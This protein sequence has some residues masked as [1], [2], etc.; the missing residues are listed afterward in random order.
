MAHE[1]YRNV[2]LTLAT[3]LLL[4]AVLRSSVTVQAQAGNGNWYVE[5]RTVLVTAPDGLGQSAG[6]GDDRPPNRR[7]LGVPHEVDVAV[8]GGS[9]S[10]RA[11]DSQADL[12]GPI[13]F[14][15]CSKGVRRRVADSPQPQNA[16]RVD[17]AGISDHFS[18]IPRF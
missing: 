9:A 18:G 4:I 17:G 5:P 11:A 14:S 1:W 15:G 16:R 12:L 10:K 7:H 13:R 3:V 2:M 8:S 6:Q